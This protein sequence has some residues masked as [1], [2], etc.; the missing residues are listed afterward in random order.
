MNTRFVPRIDKPC[1]R[2]WDELQGEGSC[3]F[4]EHCQL[5]VHNLSA[6]S[7]SEQHQLL[8]ART[9]EICIAYEQREKQ[10]I[11]GANRWLLLQRFCLPLKWA[12]AAACF[13]VSLV[14]SS[15]AATRAPSTPVSP[16]AAQQACE[17]MKVNGKMIA[18]GIMPPPPPFW[19]RILFFWEYR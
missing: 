4:C 7:A 15:C 14:M 12:R 5:H 16:T 13:A 18:G 2:N 8:T 19:H 1:S 9:G 3:R 6:L 11:V 10:V 17:P